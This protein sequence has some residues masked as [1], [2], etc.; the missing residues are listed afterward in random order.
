VRIGH[1]NRRVE[2]GSVSI[3]VTNYGTG[4]SDGMVGVIGPTRMNYQRA[5][6]AVR[7]VADGLSEALA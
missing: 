3:V 5:I 6:A 7:A 1:E 2:L 4:S